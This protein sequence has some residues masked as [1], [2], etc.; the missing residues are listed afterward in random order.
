MVAEEM[1]ATE[2]ALQPMVQEVVPVVEILP[3]EEPEVMVL[4]QSE[5]PEQV[6]PNTV[7]G[8]TGAAPISE[9]GLDAGQ[10]HP[11]GA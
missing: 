10:G 9:G 11:A 8:A 1:P 6:A 7:A 4:G 2:P 3:E 5:G